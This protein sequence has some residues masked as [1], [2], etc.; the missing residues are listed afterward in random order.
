[1]GKYID[2]RS[3]VIRHLLK[4]GVIIYLTVSAYTV[5]LD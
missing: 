5:L 3:F 4:L 1:M 2:T